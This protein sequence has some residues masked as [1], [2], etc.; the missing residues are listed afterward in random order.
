MVAL[1]LLAVQRVLLAGRAEDYPWMP[2]LA[3]LLGAGAALLGW[4][5]ITVEIADYVRLLDARS[6]GPAVWLSTELAQRCVLR[7]SAWKTKPNDHKALRP[8]L[9]M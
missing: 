6:P 7:L 5:L 2:G 3:R 9:P 4:E 1:A 8:Q